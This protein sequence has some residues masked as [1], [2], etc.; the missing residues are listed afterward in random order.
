MRASPL[1]CS[2]GDDNAAVGSRG[3]SNGCHGF[4][5]VGGIVDIVIQPASGAA[6][7]AGDPVFISA[8]TD[9][10]VTSS[11]VGGVRLVGY[12]VTGV[13]ETGAGE[14]VSTLLDLPPLINA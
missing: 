14:K 10:T 4:I 8:A 2:S 13:T 12:A 6:F 11:A 7:S 9:G 3:M 5:Q 1:A